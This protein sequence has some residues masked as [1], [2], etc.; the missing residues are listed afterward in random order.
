MIEQQFIAIA[1]AAFASAESLL[2]RLGAT[3]LILAIGIAAYAGTVGTFYNFLSRRVLYET[4]PENRKGISGLIHH[5]G[6]IVA[7]ILTYTVLFP[8]IT[9]IWFALLSTFLFLISRSAE[10][11][12][13]FVMSISVVAAIHVLAYYKEE[14]AVDLAKLLPLVLLGSAIV[15]PSLFTRELIESRLLELAQAIPEFAAFIVI[16]IALEWTLRILY[17]I[18]GTIGP[19]RQP[20]RSL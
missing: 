20:G 11:E 8:C 10:L 6:S 12:T 7:G 5:F 16:A 2:G 18:A 15:D 14:I 4:K 19:K 13:V 1:S 17:L 3:A 9:F